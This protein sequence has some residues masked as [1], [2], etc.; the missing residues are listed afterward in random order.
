MESGSPN[1]RHLSFRPRGVEWRLRPL[2]NPPRLSAGRAD[3]L[4]PPM[5]FAGSPLDRDV[6]SRDRASVQRPGEVPA[7]PKLP[8]G[9]G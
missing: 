2:L 3:R 7:D 4:D 9:L 1:S 8:I 6:S 5:P